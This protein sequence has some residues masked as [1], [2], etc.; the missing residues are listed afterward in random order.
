MAK[1]KNALRKHYVA[2]WAKET[3]GTEPQSGAWLWLAK[4]ITE[5]APE[6]DE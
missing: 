4:D 3:P 5:S 1:I 6:N 2:P